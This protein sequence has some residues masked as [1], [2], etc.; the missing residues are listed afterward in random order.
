MVEKYE[1]SMI[2]SIL[3]EEITNMDYQNINL[4]TFVCTPENLR[5]IRELVQKRDGKAFKERIE[6]Y[7]EK[8]KE[9]NPTR[10]KE[11]LE[12]I[13]R[14]YIGTLC[15]MADRGYISIGIPYPPAPIGPVEKKF[16]QIYDPE[17]YQKRIK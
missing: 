5:E 15:M 17:N 13:A 3:E 8:F 11:E 4:P 1:H 2:H 16:M 6:Q 14:S 12:E 10:N 9:S 7:R